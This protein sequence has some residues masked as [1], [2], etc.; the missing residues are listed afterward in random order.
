MKALAVLCLLGIGSLS[1][2]EIEWDGNQIKAKEP[3]QI[4]EKLH[5]KKARL[6]AGALEVA[7]PC[8]LIT[9]R[10]A[11]ARGPQKFGLSRGTKSSYALLI[12]SPEDS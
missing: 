11:T 1:W 5:C 6:R 12:L 2:A 9:G 4:L 8:V 10:I 3:I 7:F